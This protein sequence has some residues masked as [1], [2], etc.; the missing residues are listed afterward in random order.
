MWVFIYSTGLG[1]D[2]AWVG[3]ND[4][5]VEEDF[6]WTDNNDLVSAVHSF[7][8]FLKGWH[9]LFFHQS[10]GRL[11]TTLETMAEDWENLFSCSF[12]FLIKTVSPCMCVL[13][14]AFTWRNKTA[15]ISAEKIGNSCSV[16]TAKLKANVVAS[17]HAGIWKL[18]GEP[19]G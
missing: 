19:A 9:H 6:Q 1:H 2:N 7:F 10:P 14:T 15:L 8:S 16:S 4:R 11:S 12:L 18:E 3:L 5:T 17:S 13:H